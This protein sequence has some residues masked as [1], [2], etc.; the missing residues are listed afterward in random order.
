[1]I[2]DCN[3]KECPYRIAL[4]KYFDIHVWKEDCERC[5]T[6]LCEKKI[7]QEGE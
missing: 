6:E 2:M 5:G 1:M 7:P 3:C 4:I